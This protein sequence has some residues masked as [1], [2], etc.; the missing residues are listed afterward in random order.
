MVAFPVGSQV[1]NNLSPRP[2]ACLPARLQ[3]ILCS[4]AAVV[5]AFTNTIEADKFMDIAVLLGNGAYEEKQEAARHYPNDQP[6]RHYDSMIREEVDTQHIGE[7]AHSPFSYVIL[8]S[9]MRCCL[10]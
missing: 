4:T 10:C 7:S 3:V 6:R 2:L 8:S 9:G 5:L 1:R